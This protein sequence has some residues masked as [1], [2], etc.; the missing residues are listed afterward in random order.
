M[1]CG[2]LQFVPASEI[3]GGATDETGRDFQTDYKKGAAMAALYARQA[4]KAMP[5]PTGDGLLAFGVR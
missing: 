3:R 2:V 4:R 5:T 1:N